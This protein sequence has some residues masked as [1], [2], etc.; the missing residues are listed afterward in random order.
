MKIIA[1]IQARLNSTRLPN[2][3]LL[4]IC[5]IPMID[6]LI[7]RLSLSKS[8]ND[9][10]VAT[11]NNKKDFELKQHIER[12]GLI[13]EQG[14][15]EDVLSRYFEV[16]TKHKAD[17]IIRITGDCPLIDPKIVD[18]CINSFLE[19]NIDYLTNVNPPTFPDGMDVSVFS[20]DALKI[21]NR[22]TFEKYDREHVTP[23]FRKSK[24]F[25][26]SNYKNKEDFSNIRLTVDEPQ[27][28]LVIENILNYFKND[29]T[30][31]LDKI[32]KLYKVNKKLFMPNSHIKRNEG[33]SM[34]NGQKLWM[35]SK[36]IIPGGNMLLSKRPEMF[37]PNQWP[38]YFSKSKGCFV[39]DLD[40]NKYIDMSIM[41]IGTNTLGYGNNKVDFAVKDTISKGNMSTLNC[42]EEVYLAEK[43]IEIN[44]WAE[45]VRF[46][47]TGGEA[48]AIAIRIARAF[49]G[50]SKVAICGYHGWHDWYLATNLSQSDSLSTHLLPGL[51]AKGVPNELK[52][53]V[54]PFTYN[55]LQGLKDTLDVNNDIGV[56]K[57][58]V[59]RNFPPKDNFLHNVRKLCDERN[60]ILIFDECTSG[61]R[62]TFGGLN[63]KYNVNPDM[64]ILGKAIGNGYALTAVLGKKEIMQEVQNTFI[65]STFWTER[66]GPSA[67]LATLEV[68]EEIKS[69]E[70]ITNVGYKIKNIWINLAHKYDLDIEVFGILPLIKLK[71]KNKNN[72]ILKTFISQEMLKKGFLAA[73][74]VYTCIAHDDLILNLYCDAL[75][76]VFELIAKYENEH[77]L[78]NLLEGP[79]CH[80]GF[81]RL[82]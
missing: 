68:M 17:V 42:P 4:P 16:A 55:N 58:E 18:D 7:K 9:I 5:G 46:A 32:I 79:I 34:N 78:L 28:I 67:A 57:M 82:N 21:A 43:L 70:I 69:W 27:D 45:M 19:K 81:K 65:S 10:I 59:E 8:I 1:I 30:F 41:G 6:L 22:E 60:I 71:F 11:T 63:K 47:R 72:Q 38:S 33:S 54:V 15:E 53:T 52:G 39:W 80:N 31:D 12:I 37:L 75:D 49:T 62:E 74:S 2:K 73:N 26:I 24:L 64:M 23:F 14:N 20:Y 56:L 76:K 50:K 61:F 44:P 3:V 13:C 29:L 35:R 25:K 66:I 36:R 40:G 77:E 51:G 48:N